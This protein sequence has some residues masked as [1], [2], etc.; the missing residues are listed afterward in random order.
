MFESGDPDIL[1]SSCL[2]VSFPVKT[3]NDDNK[4]FLFKA[5]VQSVT[6]GGLSHATGSSYI[7]FFSDSVVDPNLVNDP[8]N[9]VDQPHHVP[10]FQTDLVPEGRSTAALSVSL[11][12]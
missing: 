6:A 8:V 4:D 10:L 12:T 2:G 3:G 7:L 5:A 11:A 9:P 1:N